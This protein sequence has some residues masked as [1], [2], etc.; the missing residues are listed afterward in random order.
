MV[1][2]STSLRRVRG[3]VTFAKIIRVWSFPWCVSHTF[4][5]NRHLSNSFS[6]RILL[7]S[8]VPAVS[9]PRM[10]IRY[11]MPFYELRNR[12]RAR[13]GYIPYA[14]YSCPRFSTPT[15]LH[16]ESLRGSVLFQ[17]VD[18]LLYVFQLILASFAIVLCLCDCRLAKSA[19]VKKGVL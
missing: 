16:Y 18:G 6:L 9:R 10:R 12:L 5:L 17:P 2:R 7:V 11:R 15:L 19:V 8:Y 3:Y 1:W 13:A 14:L 4:G